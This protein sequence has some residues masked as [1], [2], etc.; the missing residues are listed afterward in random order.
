MIA[1]PNQEPVQ[2]GDEQARTRISTAAV[3]QLQKLL[4]S[5]RMRQMADFRPMLDKITACRDKGNLPGR[6]T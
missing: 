3:S 6:C 5:S 2:A 4:E 1:R